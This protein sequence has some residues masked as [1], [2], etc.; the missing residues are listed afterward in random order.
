LAKM[1]N[2]AIQERKDERLA[3]LRKLLSAC[4]FHLANPK[5]CPLF[6]L[7]RM[8]PRTRLRWLNSLSESD[9][10]YLATYH[11]VCLTVKV[12]SRLAS[13]Q[14]KSPGQNRKSAEKQVKMLKAFI[15]G[16]P[17]AGSF[18]TRSGA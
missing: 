7:R 17:A 12:R 6:P 15:A 3:I 8:E 5:D 9:L 2:K 1:K 11:R 18:A 16:S 14:T 13:L 4:P 10:A